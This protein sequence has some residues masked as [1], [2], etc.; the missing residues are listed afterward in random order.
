MAGLREGGREKERDRERDRERKRKRE[1]ES[2]R[3]RSLSFDILNLIAFE[4]IFGYYFQIMGKMLL[5]RNP[6]CYITM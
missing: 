6:G 4:I 3:G 1:R 5:I 2:K